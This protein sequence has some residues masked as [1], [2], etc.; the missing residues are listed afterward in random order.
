TQR[1]DLAHLK[2][3]V[4]EQA[5]KSGRLVRMRPLGREA[6]ARM[7]DALGL[8]PE[9]SRL[10]VSNLSHGHPLATRYLIQALLHA[11]DVGRKHLLAGGMAFP[12]IA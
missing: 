8:E 6:V 5:E 10:A 11:D 9:I 4:K 7:A 3:A 12:D 2:P 1:L